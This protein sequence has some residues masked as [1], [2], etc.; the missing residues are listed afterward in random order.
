MIWLKIEEKE[1]LCEQVLI[2]FVFFFKLHFSVKIKKQEVV[3]QSD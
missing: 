3:A 1:Q 2:V